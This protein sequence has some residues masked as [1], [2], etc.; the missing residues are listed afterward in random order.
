MRMAP[1][2]ATNEIGMRDRVGRS[3]AYL[4]KM[5]LKLLDDC[6][7]NRQPPAATR[8][9]SRS[10]NPTPAIKLCARRFGRHGAVDS[11]QSRHKDDDLFPRAV[12]RPVNDCCGC[13][14][15]RLLHR[16]AQLDRMTL[17][18]IREPTPLKE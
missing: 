15:H 17:E 13:R 6:R 4:G 18:E 10:L 12:S 1:W 5:G 7:R 3:V 9:R 16:H 14:R 2:V 8:S 11:R